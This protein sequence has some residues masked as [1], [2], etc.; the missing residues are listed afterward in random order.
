MEL[1]EA[2]A[3]GGKAVRDCIRRFGHSPEHNYTYFLTVAEGYAKNFLL[4][5]SDGYGVLINHSRSL[6]TTTMVAEALAPREKQVEVVKEA[7]EFCFE[8]LNAKKF[9]IEQDDA[10]KEETRKAI[11]GKY[12]AL[13]V[14]YSLFWPVFDMESWAGDS[15]AGEEWKKLRN[16]R[17]KF[18][19][20]H[21]VEVVE[22][23]SVGKAELKQVVRDWAE[24][25]KLLSMGADRKDSNFAYDESYFKIID[26]GFTDVTFAKTLVVD[27][28]SCTITAG[29]EIPNSDKAYY[30]SMGLCNY[31]VE[32]LGE[33]ANLDDLCRLKEAGYK[34]VDFGGSPM[35]LLKFKLKFRPHAV[36][37][38]HV[39]AIAKK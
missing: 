4:K 36:Y 28:K 9:V 14:R 20:E 27:G 29:W 12:R 24:R 5:A 3:D 7:L 25:R 13:P 21:S 37:V 16:L 39:Y 17:N 31:S 26:E 19:R 38:T 18:Y 10:L 6:G 2:E 11:A 8:K 33:I 22:S 32:G 30:S 1:I 15:M 34:T 35:P 23:S